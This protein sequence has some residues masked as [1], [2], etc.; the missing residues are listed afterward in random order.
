MKNLRGKTKEM[1]L[2]TAPFIIKPNGQVPHEFSRPDLERGPIRAA[3]LLPR[4]GGVPGAEK[5][6]FHV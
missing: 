2:W 3:D 5:L 6:S 1:K 4:E